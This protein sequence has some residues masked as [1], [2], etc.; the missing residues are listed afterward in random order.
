MEKSSNFNEAAF[1][2]LFKKGNAACCA[3]TIVAL[4][5]YVFTLPFC[6]V[7]WYDSVAI[8][9]MARGGLTHK[10]NEWAVFITGNAAL[11]SQSWATYYIGG[12]LTEL[13]Y[14]C[15]GWLGP[16]ILLLIVYALTSGLIFFYVRRKSQSSLF[17]CAMA[18]FFFVFPR[19]AY[20]VKSGRVDMMALCFIFAALAVLVGRRNRPMRGLA[21]AVAGGLGACSV[22]TWMTAVI[23]FPALVWE[24]DDFVCNEYRDLR[25]RIWGYFVAACGF[26]VVAGLL[27]LPFLLD[28]ETTLTGLQANLA[29]NLQGS[30]GG[31][32]TQVGVYFKSLFG[33]PG[34][35]ALGAIAIFLRKR[36]WMLAVGFVVFS[37]FT[38][39]T[40][41]G[42]ARMIYFIPSMVVALAVLTGELKGR[43]R[44]F[45]VL[46]GAF[47]IVL[48]LSYVR[49]VGLRTWEDVRFREFR[50]V[51]AVQAELEKA[52]G[53]NAS[54]YTDTF[55]VYYIGRDLGWKQYRVA[56]F[57]GLDPVPY[58]AKCD[59]YVDGHCE[60]DG[61]TEEQLKI[62]GF[63]FV[64]DVCSQGQSTRPS[65]QKYGPYRLYRKVK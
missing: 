37:I 45:P 11:D 1:S 5:V 49:T 6:S 40:K 55:Q 10:I 24:V 32:M 38:A 8:N 65:A 2:L 17:A 43:S 63:H 23:A 62:A 58:L 31:K 26:F 48:A 25:Q 33:L 34:F 19:V 16:K 41:A 14:Q 52:I 30:S 50:N 39:L 61:V 9:E 27:A 56:V 4:C 54:V 18:L 15:C 7:T 29:Y 60:L 57:K 21:L 35:F 44:W 42:T 36:F 12:W 28:I 46:F 22:F 3:F 59:W 20:G 13:A 47:A 64:G 51:A 53:R